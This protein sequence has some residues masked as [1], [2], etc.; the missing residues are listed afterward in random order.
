MQTNEGGN[1]YRALAKAIFLAAG[2]FILL[3][4]LFQI[5]NSLL[6][7]IFAMVLALIINYPVSW[8]EK[9]KVKRLWGSL[10]V[11]GIILIV[12]GALT[13]FIGP[14]V[15]KQLSILINNLPEYASQLSA[16]VGSWLQDYPALQK[17]V[18]LNAASVNEWMPSI[19]QT[20]LRVGN[21]SLA[22]VEGILIFIFFICM[23]VY[24]V[25]NPRPLVELYFS[26]FP[27]EQRNK[28][29][30]ALA[31]S[32]VMLIGWIRSNL[33]GG[34]I[35][36]V[37]ITAFLSYMN[38]P[39]AWVWG[40]LAFFAELI[41][42]IGFYIMSIPPI[43]VALTVDGTTAI[44]VTIFFLALSEVM[45]DFVMPKLRSSTMKIHPVST[46]FL[47][48]AMGAAFGFTG[49]LLATPIAAI[50]K[51]FYEEFYVKTMKKDA[52]IEKR[53]DTVLYVQDEN[54]ISKKNRNKE[55]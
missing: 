17:E 41:P 23:V 30:R 34:A 8:L 13:W 32:S 40:A 49:A 47:L 6:L 31:Q 39:G 27:L 20:L 48:L 50:I 1:L 19:S 33:I 35:E 11:F 26:I 45:G 2:V 12:I 53:I 38:V 36:A 3:W 46:L 29:T 4:F 51:A 16:T 44:W 37:V 24:A 25:S 9:R 15:S 21:F 42:R 54:K 18:Q 22:L 52:E 7:L 28:A 10:I 5:L 14:K 55:L 43:L